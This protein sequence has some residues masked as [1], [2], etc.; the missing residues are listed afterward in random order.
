[1]NERL[2]RAA[3]LD[4]GLAVLAE[5]GPAGI[6]IPAIAKRLGVTKG[7]FYWHFRDLVNFENELLAAWEQQ[8]TLDV[9]RR[10]DDSESDATQR[11]RRLLSMS[12]KTNMRLAN[13]VRQWSAIDARASRA[14][15]RV[16]RERLKY[17]SALLR[18]VGWSAEEAST[19]ARWAYCAV[20]G[21]HATETATIRPDETETVLRTLL[22]PLDSIHQFSLPGAPLNGPVTRDVTQ[23]P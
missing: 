21:L 9:I 7:S 1:M 13:A 17:V 11:L 14:Q 2:D 12:S 6:K 18:D 15:K 16:D 10:L 20:I 8:Y 5:A 19:L 4:A 22:P 3:W 23:P